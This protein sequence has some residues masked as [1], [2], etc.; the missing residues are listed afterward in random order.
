[1]S[2]SILVPYA[3]GCS[4]RQRAWD[5]VRSQYESLH[6]DW[7]LIEG[8]CVGEWSKGAAVRNASEKA[9]GDVLVI[10]DADSY[11]DPD[12]LRHAVDIVETWVIPHL[13]VYRLRDRSTERVYAGETPR[14]GWTCRLPYVGPPGGGITV[15][16]RDAYETVR[17]IDDRY[18]GWGGED[19]SF[20]WALETL[21]GPST[22]LDAVLWHLWHPHPA[23]K[24]RGSA[25][26]EALVAQYTAAR[27]VPR[28]MRALIDR[29]EPAPAQQLDEPARFACRRSVVRL[30]A[31]TAR[32]V[33]GLLETAD[34]DLAVALTYAP[35]VEEVP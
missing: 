19:L 5:Y 13:M 3:S 7:E 28:L 4:W 12:V 17:G 30:G 8:T 32:F 16:T 22:R 29:V 23:P 15:V 2:V 14:P 26:S 9:T 20:G 33:N 18:I 1:M 24:L 34:P 25:E 31:R 27:Y 11:T 10:A 21:V 35:E 6:G